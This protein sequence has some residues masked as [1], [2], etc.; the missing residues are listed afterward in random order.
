MFSICDIQDLFEQTYRIRLSFSRTKQ[1]CE[2]LVLSGNLK[3]QRELN[4]K[5]NMTWFYS[6]KKIL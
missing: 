5:N 2:D 1:I 3:K 6:F 4:R